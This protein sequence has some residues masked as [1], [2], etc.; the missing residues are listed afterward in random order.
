MNDRALWRLANR[1][2]ISFARSHRGLISLIAGIATVSI[3]AVTLAAVVSGASST[4]ASNHVTYTQVTL[5]VPTEYAG[6]VMIASIAIKGGTAAV[7]VTVPSGWTQI[8]RTDNDTNVTLV[9]YYKVATGSSEPANYTWTIQDS[10]RAEGGIT[11]YGSVDTSNP[12]GIVAAN[13]GRTR[14]A[15]APSIT[16]GSPQEQIVALFATDVG[17]TSSAGDFLSPTTTG[18]TQ[19]YNVSNGSLG[20][21]I[22]S[23]DKS[24]ASAG[25]TGSISSGTA[26]NKVRD[27]ATQTIAL[28]T[29]CAL[30]SCPV[31]YWKLDGNSNDAVGSNNGTDINVTYS[32]ADGK[33]NQGAAFD[34]SLSS[35][36]DI[37][38]VL[39]GPVNLSV[40]AWIKTTSDGFIVSQ[41][42]SGGQFGQWGLVVLN[43]KVTVFAEGG[44]NGVAGT[45]Q[46]NST[47]TD[48]NWHLVGVAQN[49]STYTFYLDGVP[50][51]SVTSGTAV[52]YDPNLA[53]AIG[54]DRRGGLYTSGND[55]FTGS[56]D[57]VSVWNTA[58]SAADF[59]AL[60]NSGAGVQYPF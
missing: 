34:G 55:P 45:V 35:Q 57:E 17:T 51:G 41:R 26:D 6:D 22:A 30:S 11:D 40:S 16:T 20:P 18:M 2:W 21:S 8:A 13:V 32:T 56:I 31:A 29:R 59:S 7:M 37:G 46:G 15:T 14:V 24:Q 58:L 19:K 39:S 50:D 12:I 48:G 5:P 53:G 38:P 60:Y 9:S 33:V 3:G 49:G 25:S 36:I 1:S 47:V 43:G 42:N 44:G 4:G 28:H 52:S 27:W 10:T 23:F 54:I